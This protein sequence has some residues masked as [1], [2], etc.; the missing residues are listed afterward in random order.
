MDFQPVVIG[1][2]WNVHFRG[3]NFERFRFLSVEQ[4]ESEIMSETTPT[5]VFA[6]ETIKGCSQRCNLTGRQ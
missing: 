2:R 3:K 1:M 5:L 6:P 4:C